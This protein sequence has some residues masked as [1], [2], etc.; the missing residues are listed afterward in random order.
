M[1]L[2]SMD[3]A[4]GMLFQN[5]HFED[6]EFP[7]AFKPSRAASDQQD[8]FRT[9][10]NQ[11]TRSSSP[12]SDRGNSGTAWSL[13]SELHATGQCR[14]CAWFWK[15]QGCANGVDCRHCHSCPQD[16]IKTRKKVKHFAMNHG[17]D[18]VEFRTRSRKKIEPSQNGMQSF[19]RKIDH[20]HTNPHSA[21]HGHDMAGAL[22]SR[23]PEME[24]S[25]NRLLESMVLSANALL[26]DSERDALRIAL[27]PG[28][29]PAHLTWSEPGHHGSKKSC[30]YS[31]R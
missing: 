15:P 24:I 30:M 28:R 17:L 22:H 31:P 25:R 6:T 3:I 11:S 18:E 29:V 2:L 26:S 20:L 4:D 7:Y 10:S 16:E 19:C 1:A 13:G 14:P 23:M 5:P 9:R 21:V 12:L 8:L 27:A